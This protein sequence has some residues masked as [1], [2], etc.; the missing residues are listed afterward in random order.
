[1]RS[2]TRIFRGKSALVTGGLGFIGSNLA[3]TLLGAGA[4]VTVVDS[5]QPEYGGRRR[6]LAGLS[7]RLA[8][9]IADIRDGRALGA[10][11][12]VNLKTYPAKVEDGNILIQVG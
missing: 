12:C 4:K 5:L 1:M 6:N 10:P 2:W 7:G 11:V 8:V 3:R 9:H